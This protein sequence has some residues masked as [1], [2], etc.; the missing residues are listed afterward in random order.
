[1]STLESLLALTD[2]A[3]SATGIKKGPRLKISIFCNK[4]LAGGS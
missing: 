3:L 1:V 4:L 2:D